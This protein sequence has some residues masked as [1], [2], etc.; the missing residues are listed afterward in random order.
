M[1]KIPTVPPPCQSYPDPLDLIF[2]SGSLNFIA[3]A[4]GTGKTALL[5]DILNRFRTGQ[6]IF[7]HTPSPVTDIGVIAADRKWA[8]GAGLWFTRVGFPDVKFYSMLDDPQFD[9]RTLRKRW[10]RTTRLLEM[11]DRLQLR[12]GGL[13]FVDPAGMFLGGNLNDYDG[14]AVA[15][16]EIRVMLRD[17][18][19]TM[20]ATAHTGKMK[21]DKRERYLRPQDAILGSA[22]QYAYADTQ[23]YLA[24]PDELGKGYYAFMWHPHMTKP[25]TFALERDEQGLFVPYVGADRAA[26]A[27]VLA[28]FPDTP[29]E[30][31]LNILV[32]L[33]DA[34]PLS[35]RTVLRV[36]QTLVEEGTL[37]KPRHG[38]YVRVLTH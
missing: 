19:L 34:I 27:R 9:P 35:R 25:E 33:A 3:G 26:C 11:V 6:S 17:R 32:E 5:A 24:A 15:C 10:E 12:R 14:C 13:L 2:T 38:V 29:T 36:L 21:A 4:A 22:G 8:S 31:P 37:E 30:M 16:M 28:L 20:L 18:D 7:G 23:C 1:K